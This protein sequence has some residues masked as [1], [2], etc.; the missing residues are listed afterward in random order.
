M[1][2]QKFEI[3]IVNKM[4][5]HIEAIED[6]YRD[7]SDDSKERFFNEF[8]PQNRPDAAIRNLSVTLYDCLDILQER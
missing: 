3:D 1:S 4:L 6:L 7:L 5:A 2:N 8:S